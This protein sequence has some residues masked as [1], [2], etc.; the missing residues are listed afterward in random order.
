MGGQDVGD[1]SDVFDA[2]FGGGRGGGQ[3][4]QQRN[5]NAPI[6]GYILIFITSNYNNI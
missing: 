2:F 4:Q 3:R 5:P 1:L 6:A